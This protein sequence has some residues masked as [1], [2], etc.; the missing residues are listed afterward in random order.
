M[1]RIFV[2]GSKGK[3]EVVLGKRETH[4][5]RDVL[6]LKKGDRVIIFDEEEGEGCLKDFSTGQAVIS[7]VKWNKIERDLSFSLTLGQA[8]LKGEKMDLVMEKATE[9]GAS[10]IIPLL[11]ERVIPRDRG[12][13]KQKRW[14]R[15][16]NE[17][18]W[19]SRRL[20]PPAISAPLTLESFL[21]KIF[22]GLKIVPWEE[23]KKTALFKLLKERSRP[24]E[25]AVVIGPEGGFSEG[26][27]KLLRA[28]G[29][30]T[31]SLGPF[32]LRSE[33][34]AIYTLSCLTGFYNE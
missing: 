15:I 20:S 31:V 27:I 7:V 6:R 22:N 21:K 33:T 1:P 28:A 34:A 25:I 19:Q 11:T 3:E 5:L 16:S 12:L 9:I 23:D 10:S 13:E 30:E 17:A 14:E 24:R 32:I 29:F 8:V 4:Y 2:K 18:S 26:E